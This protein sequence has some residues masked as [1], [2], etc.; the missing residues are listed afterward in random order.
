MSP[1][2]ASG[3][4]M[5][6]AACV[7]QLASPCFICGSEERA[8]SR[9]WRSFCTAGSSLDFSTSLDFKD[10]TS[11]TFNPLH[12]PP[13]LA[14]FTALMRLSKTLAVC[15]RDLDVMVA[16]SKHFGNR[17]QEAMRFGMLGETEGSALIAHGEA[18]R[19]RERAAVAPMQRFYGGFVREVNLQLEAWLRRCMPG[20]SVHIPLQRMVVIGSRTPECVL[21]V[22]RPLAHALRLDVRSVLNA[23]RAFAAAS[24]SLVQKSVAEARTQQDNKAAGAEAWSWPRGS[25]MEPAACGGELMLKSG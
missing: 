1:P 7:R 4:G 3:R 19:R 5:A 23:T 22:A 10:R 11:S 2:A 9:R 18:S 25:A 6:G 14:I 21:A 8:Q 16:T 24:L 17:V 12:A 13:T 20:R 15:E